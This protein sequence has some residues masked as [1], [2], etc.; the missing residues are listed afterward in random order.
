MIARFFERLERWTCRLYRIDPARLRREEDLRAALLRRVIVA[1]GLACLLY[2]AL[3]AVGVLSSS[4]FPFDAIELALTLV[5]CQWLL[6]RGK[7]STATVLLLVVLS[8][9]AGFAVAEHGIASPAP[10]LFLPSLLV[11]GLLVGGYFLSSWTAICCLVLLWVA[12]RVWWRQPEPPGVLELI[13][14]LLFWSLMFAAVGWLVHLFTVHLERRLQVERGQTSALRRMLT[15]MVAETPLEG[16]LDRLLGVIGDELG[17]AHVSLWQFHGSDKQVTL[18]A[19]TARGDEVFDDATWS[20][21]DASSIR[22]DFARSPQV[23][24]IAL[25]QSDARVCGWPL[26]FSNQT[27]ELCL[28]PIIVGSA[29]VG[30]IGIDYHHIARFSQERIELAQVLA[31]QLSL[32]LQICNMAKRERGAAITEERNRMA[33]EIHD[34]LA[35]GLTGIVIQLNAAQALLSGNPVAAEKHLATARDL[36]RASLGEARRSI[37]ALRPLALEEG[38]LAMALAC[39]VDQL[40]SGEN[41]QIAFAIT[42]EIRSLPPYIELNILRIGQEAITN[43]VRHSRGS[44]VSVRL[45]YDQASLQLEIEDN[46]SGDIALTKSSSDGGLGLPGMEERAQRLGGRFSLCS[47]PGQGTLLT[48][49]VPAL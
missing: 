19:T 32:F 8:H 24:Q 6:H 18:M 28:V 41:T 17:A 31:L 15:V 16:L 5:V 9:P 36:A 23:I 21:L 4:I 25:P 49:T 27:S 11:C 43:A 30:M 45:H 13:R 39:V 14:P 12:V 42:G 33:Q 3:V 7:V 20:A 47:I 48:V 1:A 26:L 10:S 38:N 46:G 37:W 29:A 22:Q 34:S 35:Q 2:V 40:T 44:R